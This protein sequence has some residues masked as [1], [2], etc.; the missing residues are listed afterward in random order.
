MIGTVDGRRCLSTRLM[1]V[2]TPPE[3][4]DVRYY[5]IYRHMIRAPNGSVSV[6]LDDVPLVRS[7]LALLR[8]LMQLRHW[9]TE[10]SPLHDFTPEKGAAEGA[11]FAV[12]VIGVEPVTMQ[13]VYAIQEYNMNG[14]YFNCE[15]VDVLSVKG[16]VRYADRTRLDMI[17][18][19][20]AGPSAS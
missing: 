11:S 20:P 4:I 10:D 3:L 15:F 16:G 5:L 17:R 18:L 14:V 13:S 7:T 19:Q 6:R 9:I 8:G 1:L 2:A 12:V